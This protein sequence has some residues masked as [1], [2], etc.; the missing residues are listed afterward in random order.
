MKGANSLEQIGG[1]LTEADR[2]YRALV[3]RKS[4][5]RRARSPDFNVFRLIRREEYEVTTHQ[6]ILANLLDP[7]GSHNQGNLFL[8]PF[9]ELITQRSGLLLPPPNAAWEVDH[10]REYIDVRLRNIDCGARVIVEC[11]WNAP[12]REGQVV[13]YWLQERRRTALSRI[14]VV[15]L[16]PSGRKPSL[17]QY[18]NNHPEFRADLILMSYKKDLARLL[19]N[20]IPLVAAPRVRETLVQYSQL[21][22]FDGTGES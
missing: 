10:G 8:K 12:N 11:K 18:V 9:L 16:T 1:L 4:Q 6:S 5:R 21:L 2:M 7:N 15:Y 19:S 17:G 3:D 14:P 22:K 13:D 20:A